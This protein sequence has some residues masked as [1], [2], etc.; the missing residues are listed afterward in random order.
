MISKTDRFPNY[1]K[2]TEMA[3]LLFLNT[4][5]SLIPDVMTIARHPKVRKIKPY[6]YLLD[7]Y[8]DDGQDLID[9]S[10]YGFTIIQKRTGRYV[11]FYNEKNPYE[12]IRFTLAHELGHI[13]LGHNGDNTSCE[14]KEANC[15]ARN[16]LCPLPV[17]DFFKLRGV[18]DYARFFR[19]SRTMASITLSQRHCDRELIRK[20]LY[21]K[22]KQMTY[23]QAQRICPTAEFGF[24]I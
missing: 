8:G 22:I 9:S 14:E 18:E 13:I 19:V 6:S 23:E 3:Y 2:A 16:F 24:V 11:V 15:F 4:S 17:A 5:I 20:D 21:D 10:D 12:V 7:R 1:K